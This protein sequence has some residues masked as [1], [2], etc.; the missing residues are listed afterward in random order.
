M[1]YIDKWVNTLNS[2]NYCDTDYILDKIGVIII[3]SLE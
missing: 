1:R 2:D 3:N